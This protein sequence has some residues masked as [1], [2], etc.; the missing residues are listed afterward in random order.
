[1][2]GIAGVVDFEKT[3][4]IDEL[5]A[6]RDS[7]IHRGP[8]SFGHYLD[9]SKHIGLGHR[10]LAIIDLSLNGHQ[11]MWNA[12]GTLAI[13]FN[14]EIYNFVEIK[15]T[16]IERGFEF[17]STSDT[18]VIIYGYEEWGDEFIKKLNGMFAFALLDLR[19]PN[20]RLLIGRD[21]IG[22]KPLYYLRQ[23]NRITF[24]SEAHGLYKNLT[25]SYDSINPL[26]LECYLAFGYVPPMMSFISDVN[27]L[28]AGHLMEFTRTGSQQWAYWK[29]PKGLVNE[30][31]TTSDALDK[32]DVLLHESV[33]RR[34]ISDVP[35]GVFLSGGIDSGLVTAIAAKYSQN[36][37]NTFSVAFK[38][39]ADE[40]K[41]A[42]L[43]AKMYGT[44]HEE[45]VVDNDLIQHLPRLIWNCSEPFADMSILPTYAMSVV[46]RE[47]I[48][49]AL[50]GDG[51]DESFAGY[52]NIYI[53]SQAELLKKIAPTFV[54]QGIQAFTKQWRDVHPVI[55]QSDTLFHYS[56]APIPDLYDL[57]DNWGQFHRLHLL[58]DDW[59]N[60]CSSSNPLTIISTLEANVSA[61][62]RLKK[63]EYIDL[64]MR[65]PGDYLRKVD[66]ASMAASLEIRSPF[67]DYQIIEYASQLPT[68]IK[69]TSGKQKGLLRKLASR[70]LPEELLTAP[71]KGFSTDIQLLLGS[72]WSRVVDQYIVNGILLR[73]EFFKP[74][75][76]KSILA[77][78]ENGEGN[79]VQRLW[80]LICLEIWF[81]LYI[82]KS[83]EP[84]SPLL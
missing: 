38:N 71:K 66:I 73:T 30:E 20:T 12:E 34:L 22:K 77:Q 76:I 74:Q 52:R 75:Y 26:A 83:I 82:D 61:L 54:L 70:Y 18:E 31:A 25:L 19:T 78:N 10:R 57:V 81:R 3:I 55:R 2:C 21:R 39:G 51:G 47:H 48:T 5:I 13:V 15:Q 65:L 72:D 63:Q 14:G 32:I 16:L 84:D 59:L 45:L 50:S 9:P 40:R 46:A 37:L 11:P 27:K 60:N 80:I 23:G 28:P 36:Q 58:S 62:S 29:V 56:L 49:V 4:E 1:M 17:K 8:D 44:K 33:K 64:H 69:M 68:S 7:M 24:A 67:L 53:T 6:L 35:L 79:H 41:H 43:V 42:R